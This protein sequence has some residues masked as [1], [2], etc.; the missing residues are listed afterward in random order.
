MSVDRSD[1][2]QAA[3]REAFQSFLSQAQ[4]QGW[5]RAEV[6]LAVA[7]FSRRELVIL[8]KEDVLGVQKSA[9]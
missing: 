8:V 5:V 6:L 7:D 4:E 1:E 3:I 2:C 9:P